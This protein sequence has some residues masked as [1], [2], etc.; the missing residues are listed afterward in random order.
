MN[1]N[2]NYAVRFGSVLVK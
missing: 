2:L 1:K